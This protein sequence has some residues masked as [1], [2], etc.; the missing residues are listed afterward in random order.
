MLDVRA[1]WLAFAAVAVV[2]GVQP[3][4]LKHA[5]DHIKD[6]M[7]VFAAPVEEL[8]ADSGLEHTGVTDTGGEGG[9]EDTGAPG[10]EDTG[11]G[12]DTGVE[13]LAACWELR[14]FIGLNVP[15]PAPP[16]NILVIVLD[17]VGLDVLNVYGASP[18]AL[19]PRLDEL[20]ATGAVF[21]TAYASPVCSTTRAEL[22]TGLAPPHHGVDG[23]LSLD[24]DHGLSCEHQTLPEALR[25]AGYSTGAFGKWHLDVLDEGGIEGA[26]IHG[27]DH[28][29]GTI[30]NLG[31]AFSLDGSPQSYTNWERI[32]NGSVSWSPNYATSKTIDDAAAW[33]SKAAGPW[34]AYVA[35]HAGHAPYHAP[36]DILLSGGAVVPEADDVTLYMAML[37][38][39]DTEIG[40]L[41]DGL[42]SL[43]LSNTLVVVVGDNGTPDDIIGGNAKGTVLEAGVRVPMVFNGP[44]VA[45]G[46]RLTALAQVADISATVLT[47]AGDTPLSETGVP[48]EGVPLNDVLHD[49][50]LDG[51]RTHASNGTWHLNWLGER[52]T[53][54]SF[55][56]D[57]R[58]KLI[59]RY[60]VELGEDGWSLFDMDG[61]GE[62]RDLVLAGLDPEGQ[63]AFDALMAVH[64]E[65]WPPLVP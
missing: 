59:R 56:R 20:A 3:P 36:P 2:A 7:K 32:E 45:P 6:K 63:A 21:E 49:G 65:I 38:A 52:N 31:D 58:W 46:V 47:A 33:I 28:F 34:F 24:E 16:P 25:L 35:L 51:P 30:G 62:D 18:A 64:D 23:A 40:R 9:G 1:R 43:P 27:F 54:S 55:V 61:E 4:A 14:P 57:G 17:D 19:T 48:Y 8:H 41:L 15:K 42:G 39:A 12:G 60:S 37:E 29:A 53:E 10:G 13:P 22:M 44:G 11:G 5:K 50:A 26:R